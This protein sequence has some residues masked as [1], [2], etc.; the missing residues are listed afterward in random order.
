MKTYIKP[1]IRVK[2]MTTENFICTSFS[3]NDVLDDNHQAPT[4]NG[5]SGNGYDAASKKNDIFDTNISW[6]E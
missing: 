2:E 5:I 3:G 1:A 4:D 6:D